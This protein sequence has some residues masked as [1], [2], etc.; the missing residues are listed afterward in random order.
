MTEQGAG[1][2][3][4]TKVGGRMKSS[5]VAVAT[6][7]LVVAGCGDR[8]GA[9]T[10]SADAKWA[11]GVCQAADDVSVSFSG[12]TDALDVDVESTDSIEQ[13]QT[14]ISDAI[15]ELRQ[16]VSDLAHAVTE[17]PADADS[18]ISSAEQD[19]SSGADELQTS[20]E[21]LG[22]ALSTAVEAEDAQHFI[23]ALTDSAAALAVT[24]DAISTLASDISGYSESADEALQQ[25]F[26]DAPSCQE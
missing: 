11:D 6:F 18:A 13:A 9:E 8:D 5:T 24:E 10:L 16:S 14:E 17:L 3:H 12:L 21:D 4:T 19:L 15:D 22:D 23:A 2:A 1:A 7:I 25:A 20:V 26:D